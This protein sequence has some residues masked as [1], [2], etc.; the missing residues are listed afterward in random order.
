MYMGNG[1]VYCV[2][3]YEWIPVTG[4][5]KEMKAQTKLQKKA[6]WKESIDIKLPLTDTEVELQ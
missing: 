1:H 6:S 5:L 4:G 2:H 3:I